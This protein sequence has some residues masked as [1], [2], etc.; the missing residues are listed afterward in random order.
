MFFPDRISDLG[1]RSEFWS[2]SESS[3][4]QPDRTTLIQIIPRFRLFKNTVISAHL[5]F[6]KTTV[7]MYP[8]R[9]VIHMT[10][11]TSIPIDGASYFAHVKLRRANSPCA[12]GLPKM[13]G[14]WMRSS[15][16]LLDS[17]MFPLI[18]D[19]GEV[20]KRWVQRNVGQI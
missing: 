2:K 14:G 10:P 16:F 5:I 8:N 7:S 19:V 15:I 4:I 18:K 17:A 11:A 13:G 20:I 9:Q 3:E 1:R 12:R 6:Q